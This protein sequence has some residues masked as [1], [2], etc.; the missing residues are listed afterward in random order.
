MIK[1]CFY[2]CS[3]RSAVKKNVI[4]QNYCFVSDVLNYFCFM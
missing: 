3:S 2:C 1:N 4:Y